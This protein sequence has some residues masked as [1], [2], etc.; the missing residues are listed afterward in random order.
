MPY[1]VIVTQSI[2]CSSAPREADHELQHA[3]N[4]IDRA[5]IP[6]RKGNKP[7]HTG[8]SSRSHE[9]ERAASGKTFAGVL[10]ALL[11]P[12]SSPADASAGSGDEGDGEAPP[13]GRSG[14][15]GG[16]Q[17]RTALDLS[18]HSFSK[19]L[20]AE[21]NRSKEKKMALK[22]SK[23]RSMNNLGSS[24][25]SNLAVKDSW[26][27][28]QES[29]ESWFSRVSSTSTIPASPPELHQQHQ[30]QRKPGPGCHAR[31]FGD[32]DEMSLAVGLQ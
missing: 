6:R 16:W 29:E 24:S 17:P 25:S 9:N 27:E 8:S 32:L 20:K 12:S 23:T 13:V 31:S 26:W 4:S 5:D 10:R 22:K 18:G 7:S 1:G 28:K 11:K 21:I 15:A 3:S 30:Q 2:L 14:V 19:A